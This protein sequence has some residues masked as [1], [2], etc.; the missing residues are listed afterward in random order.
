L[1]CNKNKTP[2]F[3]FSSEEKKKKKEIEFSL[4]GLLD[5]ARYC[6]ARAAQGI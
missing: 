5:H 3:D 2:F 6:R 1:T 4:Q